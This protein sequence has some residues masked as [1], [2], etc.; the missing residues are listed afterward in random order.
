MQTFQ[1]PVTITDSSNTPAT[2][3]G[4]GVGGAPFN[5]ASLIE[6][7]AIILYGNPGL[8]GGGRPRLSLVAEPGIIDINGDDN[9]RLRLDSTGRITISDP[10]ENVRFAVDA[11]GNLSVADSSG[12]PRIILDPQNGKL[13]IPDPVGENG[14]NLDSTGRATLVDV[15]ANNLVSFDAPNGQIRIDQGGFNGI[16]LAA[17]EG[18]VSIADSTGADKIVLDVVNGSV[19]AGDVTIEGNFTTAGD[20]FINGDLTVKGDILLMGADCAEEFDIATP[21]GVEPG[22]VMVI[23]SA[24][25][26]TL[27]EYA[28]DR[29]VVGVISGAG[30]YRTGITLDKQQTQSGRMPIALVGKVYCKVDASYAPIDL[31]DLLVTSPTPGHAMKATDPARAFGAVIGK[32]LLPLERGTGLLPILV[33]LQ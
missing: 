29:R 14:I 24:G 32:A 7:S 2:I 25:S 31:G 15:L 1:A 23:E 9:T 21:T 30:A 19:F 22:S 12:T 5:P 6:A 8:S 33:S 20:R 4:R 11:S 16:R 3:I 26:L 10:R 17:L 28:Y 27:S 18:K 13:S